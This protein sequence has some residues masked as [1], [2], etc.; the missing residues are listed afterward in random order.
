MSVIEFPIGPNTTAIHAGEEPDPVTGASAPNI[1]MSTTFI[2]DANSGFSVEG[3]EE[4]AAGGI[5]NCNNS[6]SDLFC[7]SLIEPICCCNNEATSLVDAVVC[8]V[9]LAEDLVGVAVMEAGLEA[10]ICT[11]SNRCDSYG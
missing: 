8:G 9:L 3:L 11:A 6:N 5:V 10:F 1:V 2:A 7:S 4:D